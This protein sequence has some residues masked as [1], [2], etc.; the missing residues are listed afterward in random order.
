[1]EL[2]LWRWSTVAQIISALILAIFFSVLNRSMRRMELR[3][4]VHAWLA[5]LAALATTVLFW[6][7]QPKSALGF[8]LIRICYMFTKT[9]FVVLLLRGASGFAGVTIIPW[10]RMSILWVAGY[11]IAGALVFSELNAMGSAQ[12]GV[13]F[14]LFAA[15]GYLLLAKSHA[16]GAKWLAC[17]FIARAALALSESLA[18][19]SQ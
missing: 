17:G 9:L 13:M 10:R 6:F 16:P 11:A 5:N 3:P 4:W 1:M 7:L 18:H 12:S 2:L 15:S 14:I 8:L 19:A